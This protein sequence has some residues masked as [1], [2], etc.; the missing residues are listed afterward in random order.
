MQDHL[1]AAVA[2]IVLPTGMGVNLAHLVGEL[3]NALMRGHPHRSTVTWDCSDVAF[4]DLNGSRFLLAVVDG[5]DRFPQHR[6]YLSVG[7]SPVSNR[8]TPISRRH[9]G[10]ARLLAERIQR[11]IQTT[12]ISW[13]YLRGV[14]DADVIDDLADGRLPEPRLPEDLM[15]GHPCFSNAMRLA[16]SDEREI[17]QRL[18]RARKA[19][20]DPLEV[21]AA[22][23]LPSNAIRI[24][25]HLMNGALVVTALPV[26]GALVVHSALR[27]KIETTLTARAM[28]VVGAIS[29]LSQT[30]P[31]PFAALV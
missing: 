3:E 13:H 11:Q 20:Y 26:G 8:S 22:R 10:I 27:G 31:L 12:G 16:S 6:L 15:Q 2:E 18:A 5:D 30:V 25:T 23:S 14:I 9:S 24:A 7:P 19:L 4:I 21:P 28:A 29:A 17:S 1:K